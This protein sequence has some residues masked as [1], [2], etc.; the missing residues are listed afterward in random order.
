MKLKVKITFLLLFISSFSFGQMKQYHF[1]RELKGISDL[2]HKIVLPNDIFGKLSQ[3]LSDIR[4]FGIT[5]NNDTLEA[6]YLLHL[7]TGKVSHT[8]IAFKTLNA[9][10]NDKGY[11]FTFEI[12][13]LQPVNQIKL[14]FKQPNFDWQVTLE[15]SQNQREWFTVIE[16]YRILSIKNKSTDFQFT[17]LSF[18]SS[19]YR[20]FRLF[21]RSKKKPELTTAYIAQHTIL[22]ETLI[23][24][25]VKKIFTKE[26]KKAKQTEIDIEMQVPVPVS[27]INIGVKDTFDYYRPINIQY[28]T[29]SLKTEQGWKYNYNTL[30]SGTLNSLEKNEFKTSSRT[31]QKLRIIIHN[32]DNQVLNIGT[33]QVKG[34]THELTTRFTKP[35]TYYL[36]Y[37]NKKAGKPHYD[38]ERFKDK[39]PETL[40][41][42][43]LGDEQAIEKEE[44]TKPAPLF[45]NKIWLWTVM[46]V[47]ILMLGWFTLIMIRSR[48]K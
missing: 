37:G 9:S 17:K 33:I 32:Q 29:D 4:I 21:I 42:L 13:A 12:P 2:W 46:L 40:T 26:N 28:L 7:S 25:P 27:R 43:K 10:H 39:I 23:D 31:I 18:P 30:T 24:Y 6:P 38:I 19:K 45:Q 41:T 44:T 3:D 22:N 47:I 16:D 11:Y 48:D 8:N 15:G 1:T 35:A 34:Y 20:F 36:T 5:A 14:E